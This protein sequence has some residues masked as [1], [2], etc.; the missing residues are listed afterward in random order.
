[1]NFSK[2]PPM[3]TPI[4]YNVGINELTSKKQKTPNKTV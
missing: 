2:I 1:M 3:K 4:V